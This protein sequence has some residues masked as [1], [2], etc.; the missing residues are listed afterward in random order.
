MSDKYKPRVTGSRITYT[1]FYT[2]FSPFLWMHWR[3]KQFYGLE[4]VPKNKPIF[5][6]PNHYN[7][8]VEP[9]ALIHITKGRQ[10]TFLLRAAAFGKK[11][12]DKLYQH[13]NMLPIY[14]QLDGNDQLDKNNEIYSNCVWLLEHKR[15]IL[16]FPEGSHSLV[17][18]IRP[19][20]KGPLRFAFGA[21][22]KNNF[23]LDVHFVPVG[24]SYNKPF[25]FAG[26]MLINI[27]KPLRVADYIETYKQNPARG[28]NE[29]KK[30]LEKAIQDLM[31]H[32]PNDEYRDE[33]DTIRELAINQYKVQHNF[34][35]T[36]H[37][38]FLEGKK[39]I[40]RVE[41]NIQANPE[42]ALEL[43]LQAKKYRD[44]LKRK[45]LEDY[46]L[47][48][49]FKRSN[50]VGLWAFLVVFFPLFIPGIVVS[51]L[52]FYM[53]SKLA[54]KVVRD[55][56]F[57]SS[58]LWVGGMFIMTLEF[59]LVFLLTGI[60]SGHWLWALAAFGGCIPMAFFT[61]FYIRV[62]RKIKA[63]SNAFSFRTTE[64][65]QQTMG[66]RKQLLSWN[67]D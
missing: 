34:K 17:K 25:E 26:D 54:K 60:I 24:V 49:Q 4:N 55:P 23:R 59:L 7:A 64:E 39:V 51:Y 53:P 16:C 52:P 5:L 41:K 10:L 57:K 58:I 38:E 56:A 6:T 47:D 9:V 63:E 33:I 27:G 46:L 50:P 28:I 40:N 44:Q 14:R 1:I 45:K 67:H 62:W 32:I 48:E 21:E 12:V 42:A 20:K 15:V 65:G 3:R 19:F 36:L 22:E 31:V 37:E 13:L 11:A 30:D 29:L 2:W 18:K 8:F 35:T 66:L 43:K 61:L